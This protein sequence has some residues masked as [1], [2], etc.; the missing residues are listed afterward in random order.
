[1]QKKVGGYPRA[2]STRPKPPRLFQSTCDS[3]STIAMTL[4]IFAVTSVHAEQPDPNQLTEII[5]TAQKRQTDLESTPI[6]ITA[7]SGAELQS[8]GITDITSAVMLA[9]GVAYTSAGPGKT[10]YNIRGI[11][12]NGGA[13][14]T[15]GF[16]LDE[17]PIA[18]PVHST[19]GKVA[20]DPT[21][22]DLAD[23][24][25]L[26]GPQGTLYGAGSMGGTIKLATR[27]PD[28]S[29][30]D[31]SGEAIG[32][33]TFH[34]GPNGALNGMV[35]L[36]LINDELALRIVATEKYNSGYID[37]I[38]VPNFPQP[39]V[40]STAPLTVSRGNLTNLAVAGR[41]NDVNNEHTQAV[42]VAIK[43]TPN[44][45]LSVTASSFI[46]NTFEG[47][48]SL[49]DDPPG[50]LSHYQPFNI[51]EP[52]VDQFNIYNLAVS[53]DAGVA[54]LLSSTSYTK[55]HTSQTE[56][57]SEEYNYVFGT[58]IFV[59]SSITEYHPSSQ[60]S[61][62]LR[63][64]SK[65][66]SDLQWLFGLFYSDSKDS[67]NDTSTVPQYVPIF[68]TSNVFTYS[69]PDSTTQRAAFGEVSYKL[70]KTLQGTVG[71]RWVSYTD[72]F[73]V[74]QNGLF[75]P[76]IP[77]VMT[78]QG[79]LS[80][81][82]ITPKYSLNWTPTDRALLYLTAAKGFRPG[83]ENLPVPIGNAVDSCSPGAGN[84]ASLGYNGEPGAYNA[85]SVWSYE[86]GEKTRWLNNRLEVNGS[87]FYVDWSQVQQIAYLTCGFNITTNQGRAVSK[88][89]E[90]EVTLRAGSDLTL[91]G[92]F[93][94]TDATLQNAVGG[95]VA[96]QQ[97]QDVPKETGNL[98]IE[99]DH[100][101]ASGTRLLGHASYQYVG[102]EQDRFEKPAYSLVDWRMGLGFNKLS[103]FIFA[104]NVFD[105]RP[106][107]AYDNALGV[108]IPSVNRI[109]T[110]R[111][112]TIGLDLQFKY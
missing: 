48:S 38:V 88:G 26:R 71:L 19:N 79:S 12:S 91:T 21:L 41:V 59:P 10:V 3:A 57:T 49:Y 95:G 39:T 80:A 7:R 97:L 54:T 27:Q 101:L 53:F 87:V 33:D 70:T 14:P 22:Y 46:Q 64:T 52:S 25:V 96:G 31:A 6:S 58:G 8:E 61:E 81:H 94:Y 111:P 2:C 16:Y 63:A 15:V 44:D 105:A 56:D 34:G 42:R 40:T 37:R 77:S 106:I 76:D 28:A 108:N 84:L 92:G 60:V 18:S 9:P 82:A 110:V 4:A 35:N 20:I 90:V 11:S 67:W 62:E 55:S 86:L 89:G 69:E 75:V 45:R 103:A 72:S 23:V 30:F 5:V 1:M 66:D 29:A 100:P 68:G 32:S 93:G 24:E 99:L 13:A 78:S 36:P 107:I 102:S 83:A 73:E 50:T 47:G 43:Y 74:H 65:G 112:R 51:A 17:T 98:A 109:A 85:D 104:D